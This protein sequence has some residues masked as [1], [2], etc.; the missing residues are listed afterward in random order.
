MLKTATNMLKL[1][2]IGLA[3]VIILAVARILITP[4]PTDDVNGVLQQ[5]HLVKATVVLL[6]AVQSQPTPPSTVGLLRFRF[7]P[8]IQNNRL[9]LIC[10]LLC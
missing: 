9:D 7:Q 3:I 4:D 1:A 5:R 2:K 6:F 8:P 10:V